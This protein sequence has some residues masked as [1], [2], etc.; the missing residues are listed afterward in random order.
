M[1]GETN[2]SET[3]LVVQWLRLHIFTIGGTSSIPGRASKILRAAQRS[4]KKKNYSIVQAGELCGV[5]DSS[6]ST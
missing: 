1:H 5:C 2:Y 6:D 4:Q 3:F